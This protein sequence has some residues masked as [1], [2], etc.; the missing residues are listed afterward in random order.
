MK[1]KEFKDKINKIANDYNL[2]LEVTENDFFLYLENEVEML[3]TISKSANCIIDTSYKGFL[4]LPESL[5]QTL[6]DTIDELARTPI[7]ERGK[8]KKYY[9]K[10]RFLNG[11]VNQFL[12]R[13]LIDKRLDLS[14]KKDYA[15]LQTK[16]TQEEID[17][18]KEKY[19]TDLKD[20]EIIEVESWKQE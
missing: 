11:D 19:D 3:A 17:E 13:N 12:N 2:I 4:K 16:F 6:F 14:T 18:I 9:L 20:F 10:H 15:A 1:Y 5:R 7:S 8:E